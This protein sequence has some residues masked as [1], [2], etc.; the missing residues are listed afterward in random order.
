[1]VICFSRQRISAHTRV[2]IINSRRKAEV[3]PL[4]CTA[5]WVVVYSVNNSAWSVLYLLIERTHPE[6]E[7]LCARRPGNLLRR[8]LE[9]PILF[10]S[11]VYW[12]NM[13]EGLRGSWCDFLYQ[14]LRESTEEELT[15]KEG[16][17]DFFSGSLFIGS[18]LFLTLLMYV[19]ETFL[20]E[21]SSLVN[22]WV[23][24]REME[25]LEP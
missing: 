2:A 7:C 22:L 23:R 21:H 19:L 14:Q 3:A 6:Q 9:K 4:S 8:Q 18:Q 13:P 12:F 24:F 10:P 1:M 11:V 15:V 17:L 20:M 25:I 5:V 16:V